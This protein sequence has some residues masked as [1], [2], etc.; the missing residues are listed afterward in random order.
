MLD[1]RPSESL[2]LR[3]VL[4]LRCFEPNHFR[5]NVIIHWIQSLA[6]KDSISVRVFIGSG[7]YRSGWEFWA[8][9]VTKEITKLL[10][11]W[12]PRD[13]K[14]QVQIYKIHRVVLESSPAPFLG[15]ATSLVALW[16]YQ[17]WGNWVL[18]Q[19]PSR[20]SDPPTKVLLLICTLYNQVIL[21]SF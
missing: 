2:V 20:W 13:L 15:H 3:H 1:R 6:T 14:N 11:S 8:I 21:L 12:Y 16:S 19:Q 5:S 17:T 4:F 7:G 18:F 9:D 10:L